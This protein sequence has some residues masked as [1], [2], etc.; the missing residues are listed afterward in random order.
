V[1]S[2]GGFVA[3]TGV[4]TPP[5]TTAPDY[6]LPTLLAWIAVCSL[7]TVHR[8]LPIAAVT[9]GAA[10]VSLAQISLGTADAVLVSAVGAVVAS[11]G[12]RLTPRGQDGERAYPGAG[13]VWALLTSI[14][15][16]GLSGLAYEWVRH[17]LGPSTPHEMVPATLAW[18]VCYVALSTG[19]TALAMSR[20]CRDPV[21]KVW[22]EHFAWAAAGYIASASLYLAAVLAHPDIGL[23]A[24]LFIPPIFFVYGSYRLHLD[25]LAAANQY[26]R[27]LENARDGAIILRNAVLVY[28]NEAFADLLGCEPAALIGREYASLLAANETI[29]TCLQ[30]SGAEAFAEQKLAREDGTSVPVEISITPVVYHG[31]EGFVQAIVRDISDRLAE[32]QTEKLRAL[33]QIA[34]GVAHDFNNSLMAIAGN[35]ALARMAGAGRPGG[36]DAR[37]DE[38]LQWAERAASDAE[39]TVRRLTAFGRPAHQDQQTLDLHQ[40]ARDVLLMT[41]PV[42]RDA[43]RAAGIEITAEVS[44][45]DGVYI[46]GIPAELREA[47]TNLIHNAVQ[48]MPTG[49]SL[50]LITAREEEWVALYVSDTGV[51]MTDAVRAQVFEPFYT[52]KGEAGSGLGLFVTYGLVTQMGGQISVHST[53]GRGATFHLRFPAAQGAVPEPVPVAPALPAGL[54]VLV[55]DDEPMIRDVIGSFLRVADVAVREVANGEAALAALNQEAFNLVITDLSMP[56]MSGM[57]LAREIRV[58]HPQIRILLLTGWAEAGEMVNESQSLVDGILTKPVSRATLFQQVTSALT[59]VRESVA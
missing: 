58:S 43:A 44:G 6:L 33:G 41:R 9:L 12:E 23:W 5:T 40:L 26:E 37:V 24:V 49:G 46:W 45:E 22:Q 30:G 55:V 39:A 52:T 1:V 19:G 57:D 8:S 14:T 34:S 31:R 7:V 50:Q 38:R 48:A 29:P 20:R 47:L 56:E 54:R 11:C 42:W 3:A 53:P 16:A 32:A 35:L 17:R 28:A 2:L 27:M 21:L 4:T 51:G 59:K 10:A 13:W 36:L 15:A 18:A 25:R